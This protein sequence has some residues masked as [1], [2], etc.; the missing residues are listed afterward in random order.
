MIRSKERLE[1]GKSTLRKHLDEIK[2]RERASRLKF[3][4]MAEKEERQALK[5]ELD[6]SIS[7]MNRALDYADGLL[8]EIRPKIESELEDL[9]R[10]SSDEYRQGLAAKEFQDDIVR[11]LRRF[12]DRVGELR[13]AIGIARNSM[14]ASYISVKK[15]YREHALMD[16]EFAAKAALQLEEEI[17]FFNDIAD[18]HDEQVENTTFENVALPRLRNF[19]YES[20]IRTQAELVADEVQDNFNKI[21][22]E[23]DELLE[24]GIGDLFSTI[25]DA[26]EQRRAASSSFVHN[27]W[28]ILRDYAC[29]AWVNESKLEDFLENLEKGMRE[30][31]S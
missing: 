10:L 20:W 15:T 11:C 28:K 29:K 1:E 24:K 22:L 8:V 23:C 2:A 21:L 30:Q 17:A 12:R 25:Q 14:A 27:Y 9:L 7:V 4:R 31:E 3:E 26:S 16:L 13:K 18:K 6:M 19:P 5:Q